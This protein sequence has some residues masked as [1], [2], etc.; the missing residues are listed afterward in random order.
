MKIKNGSTIF[1]LFVFVFLCKNN[2]YS[3]DVGLNKINKFEFK[4]TT[5]SK[6]FVTNDF[7]TLPKNEIIP[8][9]NDANFNGITVNGSENCITVP[10]VGT[11]CTEDW[12]SVANVLDGNLTNFTT[13][14]ILLT[15]IDKLTITYPTED[16]PA[17]TYAGFR[18][19]SSSIL[20]LLG[21]I[22][23][24]TQDS[25]GDTVE[26]YSPSTNLLSGTLDFSGP[27]NIG[28]VTTSSFR[29]IEIK[30]SGLLDISSL[31]VYYAFIK[32][33]EENATALPCNDVVEITNNQ[34]PV[35][36]DEIGTS[37]I[38]VSLIGDVIKNAD[39]AIDSDQTNH[40]T[41]NAGAIGV[42]VAATS[43]LSIKKQS[44]Y[45]TGLIT[46]FAAGTY[47]GFNVTL[48]NLLEVGVLDNI[49]I[50]TYLGNA[51]QESSDTSSNLIDVPLLGAATQ[52]KGFI[53][54][55]EY[56]EIR[57]TVSKP[58]G[59]TL[60]EVQVNYPIIK[61][62]CSN[63]D[64]S[65]C[66]I[67]EPWTNTSYPVEVYTPNTSGLLG[68]GNDITNL[69]NIISESTTDYAELGLNV[70]L[71][72]DLEI[73]VYDVLD[74]Y[75]GANF[76][77][78]DIEVASIADVN[79]LNNISI[80]TY[81]DGSNTL[82]ETASG[83]S[84]LLGVP[85]LSAS[86]KQTIGFLTTQEFD[87]V[88]IKFS[89][90]L[91]A[92][93]G[94]IKIYKSF[95]QKMCVTDLACNTSYALN[96]PTFSTYIDFQQTGVSDLACVGCSLNDT[97]NLLTSSDTDYAT[98]NVLASVAGS[99]SLTVRDATNTYPSGSYAGFA[100]NYD[101]SLV[102][103][104]L[105]N[106]S[107]KIETLDANG[108]VIESQTGSNLIGLS[109]LT[110][111]I[112]TAG[113]G[114]ANIGFKTTQ[115]YQGIKLTVSK[116]VGVDLN[117]LLNNNEVK[118]YGAFVDTR[119]AT[120]GN[121]DTCL[122]DLSIGKTV[123]KSIL[124]LGNTIVFNITIKNTGGIAANEVKVKDLLPEGLTFNEAASVIPDNTTYD[125]ATGIW[126]FGDLEINV[127]E[128]YTL[129]LAAT[130]TKPGEIII[131]K[132]EIY[133]TNLYQLDIDSTPNSNN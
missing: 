2:I 84:M 60:G 103:L 100:V 126:D 47:A 13:S 73:G 80:S 74:N 128:S 92:N 51:K 58:I 44:D 38:N 101:S 72:S 99:A 94:T 88:R 40:A 129:K 14:S 82:V 23:I 27:T 130:I 68:V 67:Q 91:N 83:S 104:D 113:T 131:N 116:L 132:S 62:Y 71:A 8:L 95:I 7:G 79:L 108:D 39:Y 61:K 10:F 119:G 5:K 57:I 17:G 75:T 37:G 20:G 78:F 65:N 30:V 35:E 21:N 43:Y 19:E 86:N 118:V 96:A 123:E 121:F 49:I 3:I 106:N 15:D 127:G 93:V 25:N 24:T 77:G 48:A 64:T 109:L 29:K 16:I 89:S 111:L 56:D 52:N 54:T 34:Y 124:K 87:E 45:A 4:H 81:K 12:T 42:G 98:I 114:N 117:P 76:V 107:I 28:F 31:K 50:T 110:N 122:I 97:N 59:I 63:T 66:N 26:T 105:F 112:G 41:L 133:S 32:L 115:A 85:L 1:I 55:L 18:I 11:S 102:S 46:P 9:V 33:Y 125:E 22:T 69:E 70:S 6:E 120:G 36:I 90:T 53:T